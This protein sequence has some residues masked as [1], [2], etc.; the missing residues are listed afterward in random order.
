VSQLGGL[1]S[2][3]VYM[4]NCLC[5][6]SHTCCEVHLSHQHV[7][8]FIY[9]INCQR[10]IANTPPTQSLKDSKKVVSQLGG[11]EEAANAVKDNLNGAKEEENAKWNV[12]KEISE[13]VPL[14]FSHY[15]CFNISVYLC[16]LLYKCLLVP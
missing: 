8:K 16:L 7:A 9:H 3:N 4:H 15:A 12:Y 5:I 2:S 1:T 11:H 6:S 10:A 14:F 13:K